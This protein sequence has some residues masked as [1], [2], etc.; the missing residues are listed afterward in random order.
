MT[1]RIAALVGIAFALAADSVPAQQPAAAPKTAAEKPKGVRRALILC[2]HP[3]DEEHRKDFAATVEKLASGLTKHVGIA[4]TEIRILFGSSDNPMEPSGAAGPAT[5]AK[6]EE[7]VAETKRSLQPEDGLWVFCLGHGYQEGRHVY[8]SL[9]G[10]D[11]SEED[12]GK[13]FA[14]VRCREQVFFMT[15]SLSGYFLRPLAMKGRVAIAAT[16]ADQEP[17]ETVFPQHLADA[18]ENGLNLQDHDYD[19]DGKLTVFDLYVFVAKEIAQSYTADELLATEHQQL[20][21]DG[22]GFGTELQ[23]DYLPPD[24]GGR[25]PNVKPAKR[26]ASADGKLAATIGLSGFDSRH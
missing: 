22:D 5:K 25:P 8:W 9:P 12:F 16:E 23:A 3:G 13:L 15:M 14:D 17:N 4:K 26:S 20:D 1:P 2:G 6:L 7:I 11:E 18:L 10:P 24:Q 19:K 21:D